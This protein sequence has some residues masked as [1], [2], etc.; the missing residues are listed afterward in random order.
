M[1]DRERPDPED[2]QADPREAEREKTLRDQAERI[3]SGR[4]R[5][6][7]IVLNTPLR[8]ALFLGGLVGLFLLALI[9]L[10]FA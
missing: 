2:E 1:T 10:F 7:R 6:G 9:L 8:R 5:G 3:R 4:A